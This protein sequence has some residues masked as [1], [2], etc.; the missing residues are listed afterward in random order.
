MEEAEILTATDAS[1]GFSELL[2]RVCY[3]GESFI[4]KKGSRLMARIVPVSPQHE[5]EVVAAAAAHEAHTVA[6][7]KKSENQIFASLLVEPAP[8]ATLTQDEAEYF[9]TILDGLRH[10]ALAD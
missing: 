10:P 9:Q 1:R 2:H 4:I 5:P 3:G 8:P 6:P 7:A